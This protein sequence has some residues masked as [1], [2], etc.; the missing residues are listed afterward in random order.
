M[1]KQMKCIVVAILLSSLCLLL[2]FAIVKISLLIKNKRRVSPYI[3]KPK[4]KESISLVDRI[5]QIFLFLMKKMSS[6]FTSHNMFNKYSKRFE[7][8]LIYIKKEGFT[9]MDF[10]ASK[11]ILAFVIDLLYFLVLGI[12]TYHFNLLNFLILNIFSFY[13]VDIILFILYHN[14]KK[15]LEEQL[16]QAIII[17]NNAFKSGKNIYQAVQIIKDEIPSPMKEEFDIIAKD[18]EYGLDINTIFER[19]YNRIKIEE[20]KYITSSLA[21]LN[22]TGGSIV[23]VFSMI[24]KTFY[25]RLKI[26]SELKSLTASSRLLRNILCSLPFIFILVILLLDPE[27]FM[28][29]VSSPVG[30]VITCILVILYALYV[31]IIKAVMKVDE[32]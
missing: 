10:L 6:F 18:M 31:V 27:Y 1:E 7:R 4:D 15:L 14:K 29:L 16:L 12:R 19:F 26:R 5:V 2:G 28:P 22:K 25:N 13:S 30:I 21:L 8:Y 24:E 11:F 23:S 17:M 3:I 32:I 9:D 20:A